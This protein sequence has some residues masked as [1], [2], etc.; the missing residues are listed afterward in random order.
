MYYHYY[1][2]FYS[3]I[4]PFSC[5]TTDWSSVLNSNTQH[6]ITHIWTELENLTNS[7]K[8][9]YPDKQIVIDRK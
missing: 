8:S 2:M 7:V 1:R 4:Q 5:N 6:H 9:V 3:T